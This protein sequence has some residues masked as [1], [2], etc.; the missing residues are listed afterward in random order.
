MGTVIGWCLGWPLFQ[1]SWD[2]GNV[3]MTDQ[4]G[5]ARTLLE[6]QLQAQDA[7]PPDL[8]ARGETQEHTTSIVGV[9]LG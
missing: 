9:R 2:L 8:G 5:G 3:G 4:G 1:G 7:D 6:R